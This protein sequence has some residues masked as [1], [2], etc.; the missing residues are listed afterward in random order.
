MSQQPPQQQQ[1]KDAQLHV[2][3]QHNS[4]GVTEMATNTDAASAAHQNGS[5]GSPASHGKGRAGSGGVLGGIFGKVYAFGGIR[6]LV[7]MILCLQNS[8]FTVLRRYSLGVLKE[9]YSKVRR[10]VV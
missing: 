8:M 1:D 5:G 6:F 7:L 3:K 9:D 10:A 4:D 2:L